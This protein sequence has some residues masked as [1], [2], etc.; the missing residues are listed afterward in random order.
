MNPKRIFIIAIILVLVIIAT[1]IL[2]INKPFLYAGTLEVTKVD[3]SSRLAAAINQVKVYE[4][5]RVSEGE[6]LVTFLG[7]DFKVTAELAKE[8]YNRYNKLVKQGFTTPENIDQLTNALEE[9]IIKVKW[10]SLSSPLNGTVLDRYHEPGEWMSPGTKILTLANIKD[11][12]AYIYVPQPMIA[13]LALGM[14]LKGYIPELNNRQFEGK[15]IK[16]NEEAEFTPKNVQTQSERE[17][18]IYGVKVS[19]LESNQE[20]IL[21]PGMTIEVE[22]PK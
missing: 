19:F 18:L 8:N 11:I 12:W 6:E 13:K 10:L 16:I 7:E 21:K 1:Y 15:I 17:R 4:G 2:S 20:E 5:D 9:A 14:K 3:I 22:L